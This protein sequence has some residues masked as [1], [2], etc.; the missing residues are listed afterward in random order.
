[1]VLKINKT[2]EL[3]IGVLILFF[4]LNNVSLSGIKIFYLLLPLIIVMF[5]FKR[6]FRVYLE[7]K[8]FALFVFFSFLSIL[9]AILSNDNTVVLV[10]LKS[11]GVITLIMLITYVISNVVDISSIRTYSN[12]SLLGIVIIFINFISHLN[13]GRYQGFF[14]DSNYFNSAIV[15]FIFFIL[16][17]LN[18]T[19]N[20]SIIKK[21]L[22]VTAVIVLSII[23]LFT[24]SRSGILALMTFYFFYFL[25]QLKNRTFIRLFKSFVF[26]LFILT[27]SFFL[28]ISVNKTFLNDSQQQIKYVM[29]RFSAEEGSSDGNSSFM[30]INEIRTGLNMMEDNPISLFM[31]NGIGS[32]S[33]IEHFSKYKYYVS[34]NTT[35]IHNT[36]SAVFIE[37]GII[38]F[39]IFLWILFLTF[40]EIRK[41]KYKNILYA[42]FFSQLII[43][44]F[45]W[46]ILFLPFWI[47]IFI[48]LSI[49]K[50]KEQI[51]NEVENEN[52]ACI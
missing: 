7:N 18:H 27:L 48:M 8:L 21:V 5:S 15:L 35:R 10:T 16:L 44:T 9:P 25:F 34:L 26:L 32:T 13:D 17:D 1:M 43:A 47:S 3:F 33:A 14:N 31:G 12:L 19:K 42:L 24:A 2:L 39:I 30:R 20:L 40:R 41:S 23:T 22:S 29:A 28:I 4:F 50:K 51:G 11:V 52:I 46:T 49:A 6:Y 38:N 36:F 37:Q 45:I